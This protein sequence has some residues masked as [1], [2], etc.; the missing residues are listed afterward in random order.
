MKQFACLPPEFHTYD[1]LRELVVDEGSKQ[2]D[3][4]AESLNNLVHKGWLLQNSE[5]DSY[6]MHR[7]VA[8]VVKKELE[9]NTDDTNYLIDVITQKLR[10]DEAKDNPVDK[11]LWIPF[12]KSLLS[13]FANNTSE[14]ITLLQ[15]E[16]ALVLKY[17]GDYKGA[18][19]LLEKV[20]A[21]Y[22]KNLGEEHSYTATSYSNLAL[23]LHDLGDY[24]G[25]KTLL[26]KAVASDEKNFGEEHPKTANRY[27]NLAVVLQDLGDY[28]GAKE[29]LE[30]AIASAEKNFGKGHPTTALRYS[31]LATVLKDLGDYASALEYSGK[32]VVI[33]KR[34]LPEGHPH[35]SQAEQIYQSIKSYLE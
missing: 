3:H 33:F 22:E 9:A 13:N 18:K 6:K 28:E 24:E 31:N 17:L 30:K 7:I 12:G 21:S 23:V 25:A 34:V 8:G 4:F 32:S 16:L 11:F 26:E 14:E 27:S 35:I 29:L 10:I 20:V 5:N 2:K 19:V 1:L 15:N